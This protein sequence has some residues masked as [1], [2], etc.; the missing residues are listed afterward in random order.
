MS[1]GLAAVVCTALLWAPDAPAVGGA[2]DA[3]GLAIANTADAAQEVPAGYLRL[4]VADWLLINAHPSQSNVDAAQDWAL[5]RFSMQHALRPSLQAQAEA[6]A[7]WGTRLYRGTSSTWV[8]T[9]E[10]ALRDAFVTWTL[11]PVTLR[12][13]QRI[14]IWGKNEFLAP[15]DV[16]NPID[17]RYDPWVALESPKDVRVPVLAVDVTYVT[18]IDATVQAVLIPFFTPNRVFLFGHT[19][20]VLNDGATLPWVGPLVAQLN[21]P[22]QDALQSGLVGTLLPSAAPPDWSGALRV[23]DTWAGW[24]VAATA[25]YGWDRTPQISVD[26]AA[27]RVFDALQNDPSLL[28]TDANTQAAAAAVLQRIQA[29]APLAQ[30][31]YNRLLRVAL[32]TEGV[33]DPV[34]LRADVG[35]S[36]QQVFYTQS[37]QSVSCGNARAVVGAEYM[38]GETWFVSVSGYVTAIFTP[39][40]DSLLWGFERADGPVARRWVK[41]YGALATARW[42]WVEQGLEVLAGGTYNIAPGDH[43]V[44]ARVAYTLA[45]NHT[46]ALGLFS[47]DGPNGTLGAFTARNSAAYAQYR[48]TW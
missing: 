36:P 34:V 39:P 23:S 45:D 35:F 14:F 22:A 46:L 5:A 10:V 29:G 12:V 13:G 2:G 30:A 20:S 24:D 3:G 47:T 15:A 44:W 42:A 26:P 33:V 16:L 32:E 1:F 7:L 4:A 18:P 28:V 41:V 6:W 38:Q 27:A 31:T 11:P 8:T 37:N 43:A 48:G 17:V 40:Q 19:S 21:A 25:F 9:G